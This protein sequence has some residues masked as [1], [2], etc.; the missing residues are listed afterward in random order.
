[1]GLDH[2]NI[3]RYLGAVLEEETFSI[4]QEWAAGGKA[5]YVDAK[6]KSF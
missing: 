5:V 3:V 4:F 2:P 6:N 1:M